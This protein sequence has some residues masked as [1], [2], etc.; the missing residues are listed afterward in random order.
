MPKTANT[1]SEYVMLIAFPL[2]HCTAAPQRYV[3]LTLSVLFL[4]APLHLRSKSSIIRYKTV[5]VDK[6]KTPHWISCTCFGP[7]AILMEAAFEY[8]LETLKIC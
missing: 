7:M 6:Y 3:V 5:Q 8:R 4:F 1:H 2:Q